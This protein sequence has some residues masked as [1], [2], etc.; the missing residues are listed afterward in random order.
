MSPPSPAL[1]GLSEALGLGT[2]PDAV[3]IPLR[4]LYAELDREIA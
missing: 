4:A 1:V 2:D 3:L